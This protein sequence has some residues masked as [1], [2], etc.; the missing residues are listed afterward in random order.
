MPVAINL[1][2]MGKERD[3]VIFTYDE[4]RVILYALSIGAGVDELDFIYEKNLKVFPSF[5]VVPL[6][7]M[8]V[9]YLENLNFNWA[10]VLQLEQKI[11]QHKPIPPT[12]TIILRGRVDSIYDKGDKGAIANLLFAGRREDGEL[13]YELGLTFLDR[14]AGHFGGERGMKGDRI[15]PPEGKPPDFA[16]EYP[17]PLNQAALYRLTGDKNPLHIDPEFAA[18]GG[19]DKAVLH[20]LCT[21]GYTVRAIIHRVCGS[22]PYRFK[23]FAAQFMGLV[24]PGDRLIIQGWRV[25]EKRYIIQT[26]NQDDRIVLGSAVAEVR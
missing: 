9:Y 13:L 5:A 24:F 4:D 6:T 20:G 15:I 12:G 17:I 25:D 19:F 7:P 16:V 14:S 21:Y 26:K 8:V 11:I 2:V 22:D 3:P 1:D 18:R 23:S 10:T